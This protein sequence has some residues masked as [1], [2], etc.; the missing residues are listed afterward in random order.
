MLP[1]FS[2]A[3]VEMEG[4][5]PEV[6][7]SVNLMEDARAHLSFLKEIVEHAEMFDER[8]LRNGEF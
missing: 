7:L 3:D 8:K 6:Q 4:D 1:R 5:A 2:M